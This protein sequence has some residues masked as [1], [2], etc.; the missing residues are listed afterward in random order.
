MLLK[1]EIMKYLK[2]KKKNNKRRKPK[3][4]E[5]K[6]WVKPHKR[7]SRVVKWFWRK[8][9]RSIKNVLNSKKKKSI[10]GR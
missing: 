2:K 8:I 3:R 1:T 5:D 9:K 4:S 7:G 6:L 10:F